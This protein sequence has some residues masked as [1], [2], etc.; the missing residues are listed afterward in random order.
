MGCSDVSFKSS[1]RFIDSLK[2]KEASVRINDDAEFTNQTRVE[3]K[4]LGKD[5]REM[6]IT[7]DSTC[8]SGGV[9]ESYATNKAWDLG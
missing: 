1:D 6:Y 8:E 5:A 7:Q 4:L 3:L 2:I 9:W